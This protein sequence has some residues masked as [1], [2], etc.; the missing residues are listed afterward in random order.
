MEIIG[1]AVVVINLVED[2]KENNV[3][4]N[5]LSKWLAQTGQSQKILRIL[6]MTRDNLFCFDWNE[7]EEHFLFHLVFLNRYCDTSMIV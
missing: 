1:L 3:I 7:D 4:Q 2:F 6:S 5:L